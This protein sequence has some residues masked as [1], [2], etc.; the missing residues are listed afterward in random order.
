MAHLD[1]APMDHLSVNGRHR[2]FAIWVETR[3]AVIAPCRATSGEAVLCALKVCLQVMARFNNPLRLTQANNAQEFMSGAFASHCL[4]NGVQQ[5]WSPP[6]RQWQ[7]GVA[8]SHVKMV[9][10]CGAALMAPARKPPGC[11]LMAY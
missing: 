3:Y 1:M 2:Y 10:F 4:E 11:W 8:E 6:H 5:R 7:N 9:E